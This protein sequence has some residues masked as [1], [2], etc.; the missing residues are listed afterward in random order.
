MHVCVCVCVNVCKCN[1][2]NTKLGQFDHERRS[3]C[4][5]VWV[6]HVVF[7]WHRLPFGDHLFAKLLRIGVVVCFVWR[8]QD[9]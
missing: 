4:D 7:F 3:W 9:D 5:A 1:N 2:E 6:K 8:R